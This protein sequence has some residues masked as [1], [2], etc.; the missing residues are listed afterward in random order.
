MVDIVIRKRN[1]NN[2]VVLSAKDDWKKI[3]EKHY[4]RTRKKYNPKQLK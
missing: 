4:H 1:K 3:Y 2:G